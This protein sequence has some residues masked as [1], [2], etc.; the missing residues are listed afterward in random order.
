MGLLNQLFGNQKK[1]AR[2]IILDEKKRLELWKKHVEDHKKRVEL[3]RNINYAN[4]KL[5][6]LD[7]NRL[8]T[9]LDQ[10]EALISSDIISIEE[11]ERTDEEILKDLKGLRDID[12]IH[13]LAGNVVSA[14][15]KQK[16]I[17]SLF[18]EIHRVLIAELHLIGRIRRKPEGRLDLLIE[19][20]KLIHYNEL[21]LYKVFIEDWFSTESLHQHPK[22]MSIARAVLLQQKIEEE[23]E[24][25]EEK[26]A[27]EMVKTMGE[28]KRVSRNSYRKLAEKILEE[29]IEKTDVSLDDEDY[30]EESARQIERIL[31]DESYISSLIRKFRPKYDDL[32]VKSMFLAIEKAFRAGHFFDFHTLRAYDNAKSNERSS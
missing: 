23:M 28:G 15:Q 4:A 18:N 6:V 12:H 13:S 1:L 25:A 29:V 14:K 8:K 16:H 11:E 22:I 20:F 10:I 27:D 19:L 3:A 21:R 17:L 30:F 7:E 2:E 5:I 32:K 31:K 24:T 9:V 26:M